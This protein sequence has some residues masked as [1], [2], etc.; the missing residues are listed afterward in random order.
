[1]STNIPALIIS[2]LI[3]YMCCKRLC[4]AHRLVKLVSSLTALTEYRVKIPSLKI[5][6]VKYLS[7]HKGHVAFGVSNL[8]FGD[9]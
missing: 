6:V 3:S 5:S 4:K 2:V 9:L 7:V 8:F 1:M